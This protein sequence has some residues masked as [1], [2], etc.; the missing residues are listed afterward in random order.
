MVGGKVHSWALRHQVN[1]D[2]NESLLFKCVAGMLIALD[3][4][5][6]ELEL[7]FLVLLL[8]RKHIL[9]NTKSVDIWQNISQVPILQ[10]LNLI[11]VERDNLEDLLLN[12]SHIHKCAVI[13]DVETIVIRHNINVIGLIKPNLVHSAHQFL[14]SALLRVSILGLLKLG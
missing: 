4:L 8:P 2:L 9:Q 3:I 6:A 12:G 5:K 14:S 1:Y 10:R 13:H 11:D 7:S